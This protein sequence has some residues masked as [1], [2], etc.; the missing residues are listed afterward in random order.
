[1]NH[2]HAA[3]RR[4]QAFDICAVSPTHTVPS[5]SHCFPVNVCLRVP[6]DLISVFLSVYPDFLLSDAGELKYLSFCS[7]V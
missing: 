1:M 7:Q 2:P 3:A 5:G 6:A 4:S